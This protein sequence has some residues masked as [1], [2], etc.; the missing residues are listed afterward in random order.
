MH[1]RPG[2]LAQILRDNRDHCGMGADN[3]TRYMDLGSRCHGHPPVGGPAI[4]WYIQT[5]NP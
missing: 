5:A 4:A 2:Y 1:M 3:E